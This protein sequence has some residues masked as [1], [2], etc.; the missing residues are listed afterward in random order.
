MVPLGIVSI[1]LIVLQPL[2]V[3]AWCTPCFVAVSA[4]LIMIALTLDEV[5]A[6][7]QFLGEARR[8]GQPLWRTFWLGGPFGTGRSPVSGSPRCGECPG[9]GL[10]CGHAL[11]PAPE[12][13]PERVAHARAVGGATPASRWSDAIVAALV[14][15][16][17]LPRGPVGER[18]GTGHRY[19]R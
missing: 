6:T 18:Y 5:V 2:A 15:L 12:R 16:L 13:G 4:M 11:E 9:D 19:I 7:G 10:G 14:I 1:T 3:G 8:E 17:S